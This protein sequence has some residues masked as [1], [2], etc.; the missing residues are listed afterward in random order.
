MLTVATAKSSAADAIIPNCFTVDLLPEN[1]TGKRAIW[2]S[3]SGNA[4]SALDRTGDIPRTTKGQAVDDDASR[5]MARVRDRDADAFEALYDGHHR[6]VYG[7]ALRMLGDVASAEDVT[8]GVFLKIWS[9]P[10]RFKGGN[11]AGWLVCVAR[12]YCLDVLRSKARHHDDVPEGPSADEGIEELALARLDAARVRSALEQ[13]P[14][15]QRQ[16]IELG[17]FGGITHEA[18]ANRLDL[19]LG[20]IKTR[21]RS[22]LRRLRERLEGTVTI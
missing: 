9:A 11:F 18:I 13:L 10:E 6:L 1:L 3:Q 12:N 8:Q 22:G 7:L 21:I 4:V 15:E 17:F 20:T 5:L 16:P 19:P 2:I 14:S